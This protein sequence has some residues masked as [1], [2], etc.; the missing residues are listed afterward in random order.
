MPPRPLCCRA[1]PPAMSPRYKYP[2][3]RPA[4]SP[5]YVALLCRST[6]AGRISRIERAGPLLRRSGERCLAGLVMAVFSR[7]S[8]LVAATPAMPAPAMAAFSRVSDVVAATPATPAMP[9]M[10]G[11][12]DDATPAWDDAAPVAGAVAGVAGGDHVTGRLVGP[13][14]Y[15]TGARPRTSPFFAPPW[16]SPLPDPVSL[17]LPDPVVLPLPDPVYLPPSRPRVSPPS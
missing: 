2:P 6:P 15:G 13:A 8:D 7:V 1:M 14:P 16:L 4:T 10:G 5:C 9:A 3:C 12:D 17:P 11:G